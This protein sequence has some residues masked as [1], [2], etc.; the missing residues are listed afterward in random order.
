MGAAVVKRSHSPV[1]AAHP[2]KRLTSDGPAPIVSYVGNLGIVAKIEP[3]ALKNIRLLQRR[4]LRR[5]KHRAMHPE[6]SAGAVFAYHLVP[7]HAAAN[8]CP[9]RILQSID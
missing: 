9:F 2:E 8:T 7:I 4:D 1:A 3:A 5:A 6:Y